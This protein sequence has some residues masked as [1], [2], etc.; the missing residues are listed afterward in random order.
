[1]AEPKEHGPMGTLLL[2]KPM[3]QTKPTVVGDNGLNI[4][5]T[6]QMQPLALQRSTQ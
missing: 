3:R 2:D 5:A 4:P 6:K 1:M